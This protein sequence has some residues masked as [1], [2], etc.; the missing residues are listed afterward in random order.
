M[1]ELE[2]AEYEACRNHAIDLYFSSRPQ[3]LRTRHEELL[4]EA[5][6]K[7]AYEQL[8]V[9]ITG[10]VSENKKYY[11]LVDDLLASGCLGREEEKAVLLMLTEKHYDDEIRIKREI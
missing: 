9:S 10:L 5:G 4:F 2:I 1:S 6:F 7:K 8:Q 3:L 11:A